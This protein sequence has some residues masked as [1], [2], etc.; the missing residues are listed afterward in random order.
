M[1]RRNR[2][3]R[4]GTITRESW[5]ARQAPE[6]A[7]RGHRAQLEAVE[8]A[9]GQAPSGPSDPCCRTVLLSHVNPFAFSV[10]ET[11]PTLTRPQIP[12]DRNAD[13]QL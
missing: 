3:R 7:A 6:V 10:I 1:R 13:C 5:W 12:E 4:A 2:R 11:L 8:G 9:R